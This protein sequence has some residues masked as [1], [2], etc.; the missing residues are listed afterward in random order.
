M[1][2]FVKDK[3]PLGFE[4]DVLPRDTF[5]KLLEL[6]RA[7]QRKHQHPFMLEVEVLDYDNVIKIGGTNGVLFSRG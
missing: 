7:E 3:H 2:E 5:D 6:A 1:A 4:T